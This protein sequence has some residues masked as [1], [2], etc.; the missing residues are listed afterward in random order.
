MTLLDQFKQVKLFVFDIDGVLTDGSLFIFDNG[1]FVRRMNIKDGYALQLAV[2]KG[3]GVMVISGGDAEPVKLR[4]EKLG[5]PDVFIRV[6]DKKQLM[7][8]YL[9]QKGLQWEDV[10]YMGDDIPDL[11]VMKLCGMPSCPA[12]A[13]PEIK[14]ISRYISHRKGGEGA[15]RDVLEKVMKLNGDW[16]AD[17]GIASK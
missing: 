8:D 3:Y 10:L 1:L 14:H 17:T 16:Q 15:A 7:N 13:V 12:D 4:L 5:I 9:A 2:K 6:T 11:E